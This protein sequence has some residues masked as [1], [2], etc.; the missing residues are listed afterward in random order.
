VDSSVP[1]P[2]SPSGHTL[3]PWYLVA[4]MVLT[5]FTGVHGLTTGCAYA[6]YLRDGTVPDVATAA[7]NARGAWNTSDFTA[8]RDAAEL[9]AM[10]ASAR[11]SF[12][13][14]IAAVLLSGLLV[15]ASGLAMGGRR[16]ARALALQA[17]A[18]NAALLLVTYV[19]T[20][21][22]RGAWIDALM[23]A[24]DA[25][26]G[27]AS[28]RPWFLMPGMPLWLARIKLAIFDLG[29]LLIGALALTSARTKTYFEDAARAAEAPEEP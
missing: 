10:Q 1:P 7:N 18:A 20:R 29:P 17:L 28:Q 9:L 19:L 27:E 5:W 24:A 13:L 14:A 12:P 21:N 8:L 23:R 4:A 26:P 22:V 2:P 16:G 15:V 3:R 11:V 25:M 6:M